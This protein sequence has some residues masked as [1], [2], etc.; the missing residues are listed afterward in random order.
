MAIQAF[1]YAVTMSFIYMLMSV[2]LTLIYG[3]LHILN[4]AHGELYMAAATITFFLVHE[5]GFSLLMS[6]VVALVFVCILAIVLEKFLLWPLRDSFLRVVLGIVGVQLVLMG[7]AL[8]AFGKYAEK[9]VSFPIPGNFHILGAAISYHR[10]GIIGISAVLMTG[11]YL[12]LKFSK[13]GQA[14]YA[15][16]Q[17]SEGAVLQGVNVARLRLLAMAIA[18]ALAGVAGIAAGTLTTIT[19]TMGATPLVYGLTIVLL[20]GI[21]SVPGCIIGA[22]IIGFVETYLGIY[23][24]M[25]IASMAVFIILILI[26]YL[27][28]GGLLGHE[29]S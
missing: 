11:L 10:L 21:G 12:F 7:S 24:N 8:I 5:L 17:D 22:F 9:Y 23:A 25:H 1:V 6:A 28:P 20:G 19:H 27:R 16:E 3:I 2:G 29:L 4:L 15:L 18:G 26:L 14:M 13:H